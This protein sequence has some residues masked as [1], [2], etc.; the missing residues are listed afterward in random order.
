MKYYKISK[1]E[2]KQHHLGDE[3]I[4]H[5]LI[6]RLQEPFDQKKRLS[7]THSKGDEVLLIDNSAAICSNNPINRELSC[8]VSLR[9]K[10]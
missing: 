2:R 3:S 1:P 4:T 7:S 6:Q 5:T 10:L 9:G 8:I